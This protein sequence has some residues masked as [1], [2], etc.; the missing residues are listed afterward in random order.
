[1]VRIELEAQESEESLC[2]YVRA[3]TAL[4]ALQKFY[5]VTA[6]SI[7]SKIVGM[8]ESKKYSLKKP[9]HR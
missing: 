5:T 9:V 7:N 1:M 3:G 4:F 2:S 6:I 8:S